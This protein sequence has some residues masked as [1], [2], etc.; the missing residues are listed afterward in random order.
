MDTDF[1][2]SNDAI[3]RVDRTCGLR[4]RVHATAPTEPRFVRTTCGREENTKLARPTGPKQ[5]GGRRLEA[6]GREVMNSA[7]A[8]SS[9]QPTA[10]S[11]SFLPPRPYERNSRDGFVDEEPD[12]GN[13]VTGVELGLNLHPTR[14]RL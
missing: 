3:F 5:A 9:L 7:F 13:G 2:F 8:F 10:S 1:F 12:Q 14:D 11:L 6:L 4:G